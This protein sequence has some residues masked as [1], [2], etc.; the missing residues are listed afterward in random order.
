M[1]AGRSGEE[2]EIEAERT[3][4]KGGRESLILFNNV[5]LVRPTRAPLTSLH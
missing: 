5:S 2:G 1:E 4:E 3:R